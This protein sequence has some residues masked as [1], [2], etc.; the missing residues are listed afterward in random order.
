VPSPE[1]DQKQWR[2]LTTWDGEPPS[3]CATWALL[4]DPQLPEAFRNLVRTLK[5]GL[6]DK[7]QSQA[8]DTLFR[9]GDEPAMERRARNNPWNNQFANLVSGR[10]T[11]KV[12]HQA[13]AEDLEQLGLSLKETTTEHNWLDFLITDPAEDFSLG[14]NIKNAGV[15]FDKAADFVELDPEDSLPIAT[16]KIFGSTAKQDHTPLIYVYL[17]DWELLP[18]LRPRYWSVLNEAERTVF[19]LMTSF[20]KIPRKL[21]DCFIECTV[22]DRIATLYTAVGYT[23]D[24]LEKLPFRAISGVRCQSIFYTNH[25]RSPYVYVKKMDTDPNVHV[26]VS[27]ETLQ[28]TDFMMQWLSTS[29][30]RADLLE[31]LGR[32]KPLPIPD[33]PI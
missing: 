26:S 3:Y 29:R 7:L 27:N 12:F 22:A 6:L 16:Y 10:F 15:L 25:K 18:R 24:T 17:V 32:T 9:L 8:G 13:Y 2:A 11:E 5:H 28:F 31:G 23:D 1:L 19:R 33:P 20:K 30:A 21:E 14:I 4:T